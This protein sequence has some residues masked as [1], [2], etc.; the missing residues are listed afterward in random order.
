MG[1][2][3]TQSK[4]ASTR[5]VKLAFALGAAAAAFAVTIGVVTAN[6]NGSVPQFTPGKSGGAGGPVI[7][8]QKGFSHCGDPGYPAC[9]PAP[10]PW[11]HVASDAPADVLA[12]LKSCRE[13]MAPPQAARAS[14]S[15]ASTFDDPVLVQPATT[16]NLGDYSSLP[17]FI[18]RA[19]VNGKRQVT[20][21][22]VYDPAKELLR[23][24]STSPQ[25]ANDPHYGLSFP[26]AGVTAG[27]AVAN[28]RA[29]RGIGLAA[30]ASPELVFFRAPDA[31]TRLGKPDTWTGG[32]TD[33]ANPI[34]RLKGSDGRYHFVGTD[35]KVYEPDQLP[36][37]PGLSVI[38]P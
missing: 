22:V 36:I 34:W 6:T 15:S 3:K 9:P 8:G 16:G 11:V 37:A 30:S 1:K 19:S 14:A 32:G 38:R 21:D 23:I 28:L 7:T 33:L 10:D 13:Y 4:S 12:A 18:I 2:S 35:G 27:V 20:Y 25:M 5:I 24:S 17:H 31:D 26:W 29:A